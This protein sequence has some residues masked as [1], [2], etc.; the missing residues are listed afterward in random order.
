MYSTE[1]DIEI[2]P[3]RCG[4]GPGRH[5]KSGSALNAMFTLPDDPRYLKR[6]TSSRKSLGR[7]WASMNL[8]NVFRGSTLEEITLAWSSSPFARTTPFAFPFLT[9]ICDMPD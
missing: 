8:L 1:G 3:R 9:M 7:C 4:P 5:L 2:A 6:L